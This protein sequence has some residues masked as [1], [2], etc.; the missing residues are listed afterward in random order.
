VI[1]V[2]SNSKNIILLK[3]N[4][5][6]KLLSKRV[7]GRLHSS[8]LSSVPPS[9]WDTWFGGS[10]WWHCGLASNNSTLVWRLSMMTLWTGFKQQHSTSD[11]TKSAQ[12]KKPTI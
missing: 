12:T 5:T 10:R 9:K 7:N 11:A 8:F 1:S 4:K 6:I 2:L 3:F